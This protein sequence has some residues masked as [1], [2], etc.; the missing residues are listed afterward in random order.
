MHIH[1]ARDL[2]RCATPLA[3]ALLAAACGGGGGGGSA[4]EPPPVKA[5]AQLVQVSSTSTLP[6]A[7]GLAVGS[8]LDAYTPDS[9]VQPQA[10]ADP[11]TATDVF[12]V[13]EQDRW[14]AIGA[15]AINFSASTDGG[16][17][18][19][20]IAPLPFSACGGGGGAAF[21]RASDPSI[22][23]G[24]GGIV[25]ASA[26][27][28]S[29]AGYLASGGSSAVLA[30]RSLDGGHTWQGKQ[31]LILDTGSSTGPWYF[32]DRDAIAADPAGPDVY[33]VWD[34]LTSA[35]ATASSPT[36]MSHSG[37]SGAT[38]DAARI[39]Y[40]P[41]AGPGSQTFN[42]QPLV[43]P[44]GSVVVVFS[45]FGNFATQLA[46]IRSTDHGTT[47]PASGSATV[48]ASLQPAGAKNPISGG[49]LIRDSSFMAQTAVDPASGTLAAAWEDG[50]FSGGA[51]EGIVLSLSSDK[52]AT[53]SAPV[54]VNTVKGVDA[55]D[56]AVH[57]G[58]GG[59][60]AIT[61][62]DFRDYVAGST[63]LLT[64]LWLLESTNGGASWTETRLGGPFDLNKAPPADLQAGST[65]NALF[66]GDQQGLAWNGSGWMGLNAETTAQ[67]SRVFAGRL[68]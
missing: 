19:G 42:N 33:V 32:N 50:R 65:G 16:T 5:T 23:V 63:V 37:D 3:G 21:D 13:W 54:Q 62:Y 64:S 60:I 10:A 12:G 8:A 14:N 24:K 51:H 66:L 22:S 48:V 47:W 59:R 28:M 40:D 45:L 67:G 25:L 41:G 57:F 38:W 43:L 35:S 58:S 7:C 20:A 11:A 34:R 18:W 31:T 56:P 68:P 17:T 4:P 39:I 49:P 2:R 53:W 46:A 29:A 44:D 36:W 15:R 52:G 30:S 27:G 1:L 9:A 61:Y 26:L 55:F 6:S